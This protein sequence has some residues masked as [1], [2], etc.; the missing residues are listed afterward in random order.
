ME[1]ARE[2][3]NTSSI[4]IT[5]IDAFPSHGP[6]PAPNLVPPSGG[7]LGVAFHSSETGLPVP[8]TFFVSSI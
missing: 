8:P 2:W 5:D 4:D 7:H 3:Q 1:V 6:T